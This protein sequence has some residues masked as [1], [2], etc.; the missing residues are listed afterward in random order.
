MRDNEQM[1]RDRDNQL[2]SEDRSVIE[3]IKDADPAE[4]PELVEELTRT[5][6]QELDVTNMET[7]P[8]T[9]GSS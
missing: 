4:T 7:E 1:S 3:T 8:R 6:Q 2:D 9:E 5:L